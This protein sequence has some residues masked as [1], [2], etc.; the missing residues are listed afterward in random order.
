[1]G[2]NQSKSNVI[3]P[4][5]CT[6]KCEHNAHVI[7]DKVLS[8]DIK[9]ID[10]ITQGGTISTQSA[11]ATNPRRAIEGVATELI[12]REF[13][14]TPG[15]L[16]TFL[17]L[18]H[19]M[20]QQALSTFRKRVRLSKSQLFFIFKGGNILRIAAH[21]FLSSLPSVAQKEIEDF[22]SPFFKRSDND[23]GIYLDPSIPDYELR[24]QQLAT[25][26]YY[27]QAT[28]RTIIVQDPTTYFDY[29][30]YSPEF[31]AEILTA[32]LPKLSE[33]GDVEYDKIELTKVTPD[34][35]TRFVNDDHGSLQRKV[36]SLKLQEHPSSFKITHNNALDFGTDEDDSQRS[37]FNLTRTKIHFMLTSTA[38]QVQQRIT[39]ELVDVS[40]G[41]RTDTVTREMFEDLEGAV[42]SYNLKH[43]ETGLE[44]HFRSYSL[45]HIGKDLE[46]I[47]FRQFGSYPWNDNKYAKRVNRLMYVYFVD[48]FIKRENHA[49]RLEVLQDLDTLIASPI[50]AGSK[51]RGKK[52][53]TS[54]ADLNCSNFVTRMIKLQA[55]VSGDAEDVQ[56]FVQMAEVVKTNLEFQMQ[57]LS[58]VQE[59]C[60][61]DGKLDESDIYSGNIKS[62]I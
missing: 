15:P 24:F 32:W 12:V 54:H 57:T 41:Y 22:Y 46:G 36:S 20:Y 39:G 47:L 30:R 59:Y 8:G 60:I 5:V 58:K 55:K 37:T 27:L 52:F 14:A 31:K 50:I 19:T 28:I 56:Q 61:T 13:F 42:S 48:I 21:D 17:T 35:S 45:H 18:V 7:T 43:A 6:E 10:P 26:S 44:L 38:M 62:F 2:G 16:I 34:L 40:M 51:I 4:V 53:R 29:S 23:F 11:V 49:Q 25:I 1:M 3:E 33:T 9:V